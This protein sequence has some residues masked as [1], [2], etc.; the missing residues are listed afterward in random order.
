[1]AQLKTA[2]YLRTGV[3]RKSNH[4]EINAPIP[5]L[6]S[7]EDFGDLGFTMYWESITK[8]F[9]HAPE[10]H[11]HEFPQYIIYLGGDTNNMLD[12]GGVVEITLSEDGKT[13]EKH[14]ITQSTTIYIPPGLYH[15]PLVYKKVDRP[16]M[17]IDIFFARAYERKK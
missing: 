4:P 6:N 14:T 10:P 15:G 9:T 7:N 5:V 8:P 3:T 13:M 11:K 12:L 17:F 1:M 2:K 16:F